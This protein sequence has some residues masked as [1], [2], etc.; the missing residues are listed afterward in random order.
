MAAAVGMP[1]Y[2]QSGVLRMKCALNFELRK[3]REKAIK[4]CN[5]VSTNMS[6]K[7]KEKL[8]QRADRAEDSL[9]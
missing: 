1:Q 7:S 3:E 8:Q 9:P 2:K 6:K 5:G 4:T